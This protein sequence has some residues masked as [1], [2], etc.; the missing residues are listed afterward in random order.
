MTVSGEEQ[1][2]RVRVRGLRFGFSDEIRGSLS[3]Q[4]SESLH[5]ETWAGAQDMSPPG[6]FPGPGAS[7]W[8]CFSVLPLLAVL[9]SILCY[10]G[11]AVVIRKQLLGW[12]TVGEN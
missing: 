6:G 1:S 3:H 10:L 2:V 4:K 8:V 5:V 9:I 11:Q 7:S 12:I